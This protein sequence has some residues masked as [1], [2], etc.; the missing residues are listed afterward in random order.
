[1]KCPRC[2]NELQQMNVADII[3]DVCEKG[4]GGIWFDNFELK[5]VDEQHESA[6]ELLLNVERNKN[7]QVDYSQKRACP[8][9]K[10]SIMLKHFM[11]VKKEVEVDECPTCGGVWLDYGELGQIRKQYA[12]EEER[13]QAAQAYFSELFDDKLTAMCAENEAKLEKAKKFARMFR[14]ICPS[15]YIPGKQVWGAF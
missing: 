13:K 2:E 4:C 8:K 15:Y 5:K 14:F 7:I 11:S 6:G 9:C 3:V 1:M 12:T 10:D